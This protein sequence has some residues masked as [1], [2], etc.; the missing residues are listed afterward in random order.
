MK[1]A[2]G[3]RMPHESCAEPP[4]SGVIEC[5]VGRGVKGLPNNSR[6]VVDIETPPMIADL[7]DR[8]ATAFD[9]DIDVAGVL[10][11]QAAATL[12]AAR[13]PNERPVDRSAASTVRLVLA[14]WQRDRIFAYIEANVAQTIRN[15][16]LARLIYQMVRHRTDS[17]SQPA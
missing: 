4:V 15:A 3:S 2:P 9:S 5:A 16:D 6:V 8:A 13:A 11:F 1:H 12:R 17:H 10:L 14:P 7:I